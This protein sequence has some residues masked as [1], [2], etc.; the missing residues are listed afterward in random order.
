VFSTYL[1]TG[2]G[3]TQTIN[4]GID[5]AGNGGLVWVRSR[6][7]GADHILSTTDRPVGNRVVTNS[8]TAEVNTG[9]G[10]VNS[11]SS[12]GFTVGN[13]NDVNLNMGS[14]VS[15]TF[16]KAPKF[17]DIVTYTGTGNQQTL[18]HNLGVKPGMIIVFNLSSTY[19]R[20]TWHNSIPSLN[21]IFL[22]GTSTPAYASGNPWINEPTSTHFTVGGFSAVQF[23]GHQFVA[24]LFAHDTS[25]TSIIKCG[26]YSGTGLVNLGF[27]PQYILSRCIST[28]ANWK[29][30]DSMRGITGS[31]SATLS[32][33]TTAI[34]ENSTMNITLAANGFNVNTL[35]DGAGTYIYMAI[36]RPNKPPTSGTQVFSV[37]TWS[38]SGGL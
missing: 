10:F 8:A 1:Y 29:I 23:S 11:F 17:F 27:E 30:N 9:T 14:Y 18:S 21:Y 32:A 6:T 13:G 20:Y 31:T 5:L 34:E 33:N 26:S 2:N 22:D 12:T 16:R 24:Y 7:V 19:N 38:Q 28:N 36:R 4:N 15:W 37:S 35:Q 3:S 25:A